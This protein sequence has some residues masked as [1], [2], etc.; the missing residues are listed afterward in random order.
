MGAFLCSPI[1]G[2]ASGAALARV[3]VA[4]AH[5]RAGCDTRLDKHGETA[6]RM[7]CLWLRGLCIGLIGLFCAVAV[8][9]SAVKAQAQATNAEPVQPWGLPPLPQGVGPIEKFADIKDT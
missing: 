2:N 3:K 8:P 6:M 9:G 5:C 4:A 1:A 7:R